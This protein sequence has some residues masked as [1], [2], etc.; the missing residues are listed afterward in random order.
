MLQF[1]ENYG[2]SII[3]AIVITLIVFLVIRSMLKD[4][5]NGKGSCSCGGSCDSCGACAHCHPSTKAS[6]SESK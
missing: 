3:V 2:S 6:K 5:K 4:K 1:L